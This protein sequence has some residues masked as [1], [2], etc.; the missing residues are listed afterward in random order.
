MKGKTGKTLGQTNSKNASIKLLLCT[1]TEDEKHGFEY[2]LN[3]GDNIS[4]INGTLL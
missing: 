3:N 4:A 1:R 2:I